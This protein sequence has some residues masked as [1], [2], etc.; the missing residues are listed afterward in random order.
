MN[1]VSDK[2]IIW[3]PTA[4]WFTYLHFRL[5][6][7]LE[8]QIEMSKQCPEN[9]ALISGVVC[10]MM[11]ALIYTP[12]LSSHI[13]S[14]LRNL[15]ASEI[16]RDFGTFFLHE[17]DRSKANP[18]PSLPSVD[19]AAVLADLKIQKLKRKYYH[20][21]SAPLRTNNPEISL[22]FGL[23]PSM[24]MI[25][26]AIKGC[27]WEIIPRWKAISPPE[28]SD[29]SS[30]IKSLFC[31]F[32]FEIWATLNSAHC[33]SPSLTLPE[34]VD[35]ALEMWSFDYCHAKLLQL[36][37]HPVTT[38]LDGNGPQI[39]KP[40]KDRVHYWFPRYNS[41]P[42]TPTWTVL[43]TKGQFIKIHEDL[44]TV[45]GEDAVAEQLSKLLMLCQCLPVE[46][47]RFAIWSRTAGCID[48]DTNPRYY[49]IHSVWA[50]KE[51]ES[52]ARGPPT[53][54]SVGELKK[55]FQNNRQLI[56]S[57]EPVK[58]QRIGAQKGR[59]ARNPPQNRY[60]QTKQ[61]A[62]SDNS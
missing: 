22:S 62:N 18:L 30:E 26:S 4:K 8:L 6:A 13:T 32:T 41:V 36:S 56:S 59:N 15:S 48:M 16:Q 1:Q 57:G 51:Q 24:E 54:T 37:C 14:A 58:R 49:E 38:G 7:L 53:A 29:I 11:E 31:L 40:F 25:I 35:K 21:Q 23:K 17:L 3:I 28:I 46:G 34:N 19:T 44:I 20:N 60:Q 10:Y 12:R 61:L 2:A 47:Y 42:S 50:M 55:V 9:L 43:K 33:A 45:H 52:K 27:P 5:N 39:G